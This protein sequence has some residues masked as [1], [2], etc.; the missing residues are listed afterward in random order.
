MAIQFVSGWYGAPGEGNLWALGDSVSIFVEHR[1]AVTDSGIFLQ[2]TSG[3]NQGLWLSALVTGFIWY[4]VWDA[5]GY[6]PGQLF[7]P[8]PTGTWSTFSWRDTPTS[9]QYWLNGA[10]SPAYGGHGRTPVD[11]GVRE[12]RIGHGG[13]TRQCQGDLSGFSVWKGYTLTDQDRQSLRDGAHPYTIGRGSLANYYSM[14]GD[15]ASTRI[16]DSVGGKHLSA[17]GGTP[18]K[19]E[20]QPKRRRNGFV[21]C[22]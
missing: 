13:F 16:Y 12:F 2:V 5:G 1:I 10:S 8:T 4:Q 7:T 15:Y 19:A 18:T 21:G 11:T 6:F 17:V 9:V 3:A 20:E 22:F 14:R